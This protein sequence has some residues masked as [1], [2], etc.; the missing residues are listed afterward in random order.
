[1]VFMFY[2]CLIFNLFSL[3]RNLTS[4]PSIPYLF[5]V[6][7]YPLTRWLCSQKRS[8][9]YLYVLIH[10]L[11]NHNKLV[12]QHKNQT[13][14]S[15]NIYQQVILQ[16]VSPNCWVSS[17]ILSIDK[18]TLFTK[19]FLKINVLIQLLS[20]HN[21]LVHQHKKQTSKSCININTCL[22]AFF[23]VIWSGGS[24]CSWYGQDHASDLMPKASPSLA[25]QLYLIT[26]SYYIYLK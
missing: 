8:W 18:V 2:S 19:T 11:S 9:K 20:N 10:L 7:L 5:P 12:H 6:K 15:T 17:Q 21:K 14:K 26:S 1:M 13:S 23:M 25:F 22:L 4:T 24:N 16:K 3:F